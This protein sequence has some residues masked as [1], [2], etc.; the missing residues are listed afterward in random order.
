MNCIFTP[1]FRN[2]HGTVQ[3]SSVRYRSMTRPVETTD[4]ILRKRYT[5]ALSIIA[6]LVILS[7]VAIQMSI[8]NNEDDSRVINIAGRQR[9]L[10]QRINK[11]AFGICLAQ[12][13]SERAG[14]RAEMAKSVALWEISH[15]GLQDG[16]AGMGLPG[17]NSNTIKDLFGTIQGRFS[18]ILNAA[19]TMTVLAAGESPNRNL[20]KSE[21]QKIIGN[22]GYFLEGMDTIVFQYDREAKAK[23]KLV[24]HIEVFLMFITLLVLA[25][26]ALFIFRP[27][28]KQIKE[29]IIK[30]REHEESL[31]RIFETAPVAMFLVSRKN[32][33]ILKLN[34]LAAH[35][36]DIDMNSATGQGFDS[37]WGGYFN[38]IPEL[39]DTIKSQVALNNVEADITMDGRRSGCVL[40]SSNHIGFRGEPAIIIGISDI[41]RQKE[42]ENKF[43]MLYLEFQA[44]LNGMP[45]GMALVSP[46]L[47]VLWTNKAMAGLLGLEATEAVCGHCRQLRQNFD[48]PCENCPVQ[49]C[50]A[51]GQQEIRLL[52]LPPERTVEL[53]VIPVKDDSG[54]VLKVIEVGRDV[55]E[56]KNL[57][58]QLQHS[59]KL[60]AVGKLAGGIAHDFNNILTAIMGFASLLRMKMEKDNPLRRYAE[61]ILSSSEKASGLTQGLLAFS[62]KQV[63]SPKPTDLNELIIHGQK[64]LLSLLRD[65]IELVL[66][67]H[68]ENLTIMADGIRLEQVFMNLASNARDAMPDGGKVFIS[69]GL[70]TMDEAFIQAH[71]YGKPGRYASVSVTDTGLGMDEQTRE[72]IFE[73]FFTTKEVG[74][75]TGLGLATVYGIIK[76]HDGYIGVNSEPGSGTTFVLYLPLTRETGQVKEIPEPFA[77]GGGETVLLADDNDNVRT[78]IREILENFGYNV[79]EA[80][81]GEEA[82]RE[83]S[84]HNDRID[85]LILDVIMPKKSGREVYD[86]VQQIRSN[87]KVLFIS[88]YTADIITRQR[89]LDEKLHFIEKPVTPAD[90]LSKM[91][92][93]L[94]L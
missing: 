19:K 21:L 56:Q 87:V 91:R 35:M 66:D 60:E 44:L 13:A 47:T 80:A 72:K 76:Q 38:N 14:Y 62:R 27:A 58:R 59:Q 57:E 34:N 31:V 48:P 4:R 83:F 88:G 23:V 79:I 53:R 28:E 90:L 6:C 7:Q 29:K 50:F 69:T 25:L 77:A 63:M 11:C 81:D 82:I 54:R 49:S 45:D 67:L 65:D 12:D 43:R 17:N 9:M 40:I 51:K 68:G 3:E 39:R 18:T 74:K 64:L 5:L 22:E 61:Q 70:F 1:K 94:S 2:T 92:E 26:E 10:S 52:H 73:P 30:I 37:L 8:S 46:D 15:K 36:F 16:N 85:L 71:G 33:E 84:A 42:A 75:G 41:S 32:L 24:K 78:S 20:I 93:V 86:S 89:I 55:T